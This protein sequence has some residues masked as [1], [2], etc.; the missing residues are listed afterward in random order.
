LIETEQ[1]KLIS[2]ACSFN[3]NFNQFLAS[4]DS[5][6]LPKL[7]TGIVQQPID[8]IYWQKECGAF[9]AENLWGREDDALDVMSLEG[10]D[11]KPNCYSTG[12]YEENSGKFSADLW[13]EE[14]SGW[15]YTVKPRTDCLMYVGEW[16]F[17]ETNKDVQS[18]ERWY[19]NSIEYLTN[20][21]FESALHN[22]PVYTLFSH[23]VSRVHLHDCFQGS[24]DD[25]WLL[26]I[27]LL[28]V[29]SGALD[30]YADPLKENSEPHF[31]RRRQALEAGL[32][33][34]ISPNEATANASKRLIKHFKKSGAEI[35]WMAKLED[36][37]DRK[38]YSTTNKTSPLKALVRET[39]LLSK[40]LLNTSN[41]HAGRFPTSAIQNILELVDED[42]TDESIRRYQEQYDDSDEKYLSSGRVDDHP[43]F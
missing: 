29:I 22:N 39:S 7:K 20:H 27:F 23:N 33:T 31:Q 13:V 25:D 5:R 28:R 38:P 11:L 3:S 8:N 34:L 36:V 1:R 43:P 32:G 9:Q 16:S 35:D 37:A 19:W 4:H 6:I 42:V 17:L 18:K 14:K 26:K 30:M 2:L 24:H 21:P 12:G 40:M 15:T 41:S 10:D